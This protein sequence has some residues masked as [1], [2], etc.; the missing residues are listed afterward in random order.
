MQDQA[1]V[2]I[3]FSF[4]GGPGPIFNQIQISLPKVILCKIREKVISVS[5][6]RGIQKMYK[7][8]PLAL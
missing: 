3:N 8:Y 7:M 4:C 2:N 5:E 6:K 1:N